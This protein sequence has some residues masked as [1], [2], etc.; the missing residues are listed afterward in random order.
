MGKKNKKNK[1][2][3]FTPPEKGL[4][5]A[6]GL[7]PFELNVDAIR[8][9][10]EGCPIYKQANLKIEPDASGQIDFGYHIDWEWWDRYLWS[11]PLEEMERAKSLRDHIEC[12][13]GH[14]RSVSAGIIL[15]MH[16][17]Q[18]IEQVLDGGVISDTT[19]RT[20]QFMWGIYNQPERMS[21]MLT[22]WGRDRGNLITIDYDHVMGVQYP[23]SIGIAWFE[24]LG[25]FLGYPVF[26][27]V[28]ESWFTFP[29]TERSITETKM[30]IPFS[31]VT[32]E[33]EEDYLLQDKGNAQY[34]IWVKGAVGHFVQPRVQ[35][36]LDEE[37]A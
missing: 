31:D 32:V 33:A 17:G 35:P 5:T 8:L 14:F 20:N 34:T 19:E 24:G 12:G 9:L 1:S 7:E 18:L 23:H 37:A 28:D 15:P 25:H 27:E 11:R 21:A 22:N 16:K 2:K 29:L 4:V 13:M 36:E 26:E 30:G 3:Q 6:E 10:G